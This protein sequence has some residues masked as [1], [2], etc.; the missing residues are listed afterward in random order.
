M[1]ACSHVTVT[2]H[3]QVP[4]HL[5]S[6]FESLQ[7]CPVHITRVRNAGILVWVG[8]VSV[9]HPSKLKQA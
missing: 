6:G 4:E 9:G 8:K 1:Q 5:Q 2:N 7:A 3:V